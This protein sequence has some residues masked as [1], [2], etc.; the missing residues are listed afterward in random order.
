MNRVKGN[1]APLYS[2][3]YQTRLVSP[4]STKYRIRGPRVVINT[5]GITGLQD[6]PLRK[7]NYGNACNVYGCY[8]H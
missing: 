3:G 6:R 4:R 8:E 1:I 5:Q 7:V 2:S